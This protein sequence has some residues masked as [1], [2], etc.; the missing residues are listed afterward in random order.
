[1]HKSKPGVTLGKLSKM[2]K[3]LYLNCRD[4]EGLE[5]LNNILL[6]LKP[7]KKCEEVEIKQLEAVLTKLHRKTKQIRISYI[8]PT[9]TK[10]EQ[11]YSASVMNNNKSGLERSKHIYANSI[12]ELYA[13]A[14]IY[15][16]ISVKEEAQDED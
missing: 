11:Y 6:N 3:M 14:T 15:M 12:W 8:M 7:F 4:E 5:K 10:D 9:F 2:D 16:Y 13:K 1:M